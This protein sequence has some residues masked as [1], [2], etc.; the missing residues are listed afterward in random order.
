MT[1]AVARCDNLGGFSKDEFAALGDGAKVDYVFLCGHRASNI[2]RLLKW[3]EASDNKFFLDKIRTIMQNARANG[4]ALLDLVD[5][6][7][8][9]V[10]LLRIAYFLYGGQKLSKKEALKLRE[11]ALARGAPDAQPRYIPLGQVPTTPGPE[12]Q[13]Y[14]NGQFKPRPE[15]ITTARIQ[16]LKEGLLSGETYIELEHGFIFLFYG[17][18]HRYSID[19]QHQ[20]EDPSDTVRDAK[21]HVYDVFSRGTKTN[22]AWIKKIDT[23]LEHTRALYMIKVFFRAFEAKVNKIL[24][25]AEKNI[26]RPYQDVALEKLAVIVLDNGLDAFKKETRLGLLRELEELE[27]LGINTDDLAPLTMKCLQQGL[28]TGLA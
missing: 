20:T 4:G 15:A 9:E 28:F 21:K 10:D 12:L 23:K 5:Q 1:P 24:Q 25:D 8:I 13:A 6:R 17:I 14:I 7:F 16:A 18:V 3:Y 26:P 27:Q 19:K 11:E 2:H 22:K